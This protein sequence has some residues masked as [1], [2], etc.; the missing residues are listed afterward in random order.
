[1]AKEFYDWVKLA[2][3]NKWLVIMCFGSLSSLATNAAQMVTN[4]NLV[5]EKDTAVHEVAIAFQSVIAES[6]PKIKTN[7][8]NCSILLHSH[9]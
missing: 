3:D 9:I 8:S 5:I 4:E 2:L 1:M 6:T 7:C